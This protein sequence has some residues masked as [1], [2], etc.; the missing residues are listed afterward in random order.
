MLPYAIR[1]PARSRREIKGGRGRG[2]ST[3][4]VVS[5]VLELVLARSP[6][7]AW[8]FVCLSTF[9]LKMTPRPVIQI[10]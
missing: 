2:N 3:P 1:S 8:L 10:Q 6:V 4:R 7:S 9:R 5:L